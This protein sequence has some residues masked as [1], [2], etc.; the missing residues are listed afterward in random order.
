MTDDE[1]LARLDPGP[2]AGG[3]PDLGVF[4][5]R[6]CPERPC[7]QTCAPAR[8]HQRLERAQRAAVA[9]PCE[10]LLGREEHGVLGLE[11]A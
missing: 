8:H 9:R 7:V 5:A 1:T 10:D 4:C 11:A 3:Y 2:F 6:G